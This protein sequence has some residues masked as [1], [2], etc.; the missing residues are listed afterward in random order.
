MK[1]AK[2]NSNIELLRIIS[3]LL[4]VIGH[5]MGARFEG[6]NQPISVFIG[7][8]V[9]GSWAILGVDLFVI[10][11]AWFLNV[12]RFRITRVIS[13]LL[14]AICYIIAFSIVYAIIVGVQSN[15]FSTALKSMVLYWFDG[16]FKQYHWFVMAYIVMCFAAPFMNIMLAR[17]SEK[18]LRVI[19]IIAIIA[20]ISQNFTGAGYYSFIADSVNFLFIYLIVGYI[21]RFGLTFKKPLLKS[22]I[23]IAIVI[24]GKISL[25]YINDDGIL[26]YLY[27][28]I[29]V[30]AANTYRYSPVLVLL[31]IYLFVWFYSLKPKHSRV[32]NTVAGAT[33]G[34]YLFHETFIPLNYSYISPATGDMVNQSQVSL[35]NL[36]VGW[37]CDCGYIT[38]DALFTLKI[39]SVALLIFFCGVVIELIRDS[40][41]QKPIMGWINKK[42]SV[43]LERIDNWINI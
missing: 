35:K 8:T 37:F 15:S 2:R 33:F 7:N 19:L 40:I 18:S 14:E 25:R 22:L 5:S 30:T 29:D 28:F 24:I 21:K 34:V 41:I 42:F 17:L 27:K 6:T 38:T 43:Q 26:H 11:S 12:Q 3:M 4:I 9:F 32:V 31:A 10:I 20:F 23:I 13:V 36:V 16:V 1:K 39:I